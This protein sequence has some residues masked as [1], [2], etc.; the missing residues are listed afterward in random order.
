M[1]FKRIT[2]DLACLFVKDNRKKYIFKKKYGSKIPYILHTK[3]AKAYQSIYIPIYKPNVKLCSIEPEIYNKKGERIRVMFLRDRYRSNASAQTSNLIYWDKYN[4]ELPLHLYTHGRMLETMGSPRHRFGALVETKGIKPK[5][6]E[7]FSKYQ[8]LNKD[9]DLIF[10]Y[11]EKLLNELPNARFVPFCADIKLFTKDFTMLPDLEN[12]FQQN[13]FN[14]K[15]KNISMISSRKTM[16]DLHLKR[17][18]T[19]FKLK[20]NPS[21]DTFGTFDGGALIDP[22]DS[23]KAYRYSIVFENEISGYCFTEKLTNCFATQTVPIYVGASK[24]HEIFDEDG[25][26]RV[27][28]SEIDNIENIIKQCCEDDYISRKQAIMNNFAIV[29]KYSNNEDFMYKNYINGNY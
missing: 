15:N 27:N 14:E 5:S 25:I 6:Y 29:Q 18:A 21:V 24:I 1:S 11:D 12:I 9:F 3:K 22:Y 28:E 19:A 2:V 20:N 7:I 17:I 23:L 8:G 10:T 13:L 4:F 26:I 16:C